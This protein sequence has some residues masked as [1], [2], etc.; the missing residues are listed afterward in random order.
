MKARD[1]PEFGEIQ[2]SHTD[3]RSAGASPALEFRSR[4]STLFSVGCSTDVDLQALQTRLVDDERC[5]EALQALLW[6]GQLRKVEICRW[7]GF[8]KRRG[9]NQVLQERIKD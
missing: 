4:P 1:V 8:R 6:L 3:E 5:F 2:L 9:C 7:L